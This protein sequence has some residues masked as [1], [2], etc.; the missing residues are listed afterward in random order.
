MYICHLF[1]LLVTCVVKPLQAE[2][3][4]NP[5]SVGPVE[6]CVFPWSSSQVHKPD[7]LFQFVGHSGE[8]VDGS[9]RLVL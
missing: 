3:P 1:H 8:I 6:Q 7:H 2:L 5:V 4:V 9:Q